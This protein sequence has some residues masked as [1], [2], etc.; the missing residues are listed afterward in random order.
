MISLQKI[1]HASLDIRPALEELISVH[2]L[3]NLWFRIVY[4]PYQSKLVP[5]Y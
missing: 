2:Q 1:N 5:R 3:L 4:L